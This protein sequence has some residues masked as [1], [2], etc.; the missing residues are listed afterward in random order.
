[1]YDLFDLY[2]LGRGWSWTIC[3]I[4]KYAHVPATRIQLSFHFSLKNKLLTLLTINQPLKEHHVTLR[5]IGSPV[6]HYL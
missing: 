1:M 6:M 3:E 4:I 2:D 5:Q